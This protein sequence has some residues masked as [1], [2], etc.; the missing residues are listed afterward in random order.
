MEEA[1]AEDPWHELH[2]S[3]EVP[4]KYVPPFMQ[5]SLAAKENDKK[6]DVQNDTARMDN[7]YT[8]EIEEAMDRERQR[9][10]DEAKGKTGLLQD[11]AGFPSQDNQKVD[12]L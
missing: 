6:K 9:K 12:D 8:L 1:L 11:T 7:L 3:N 2:G 10:A 4:K 5:N